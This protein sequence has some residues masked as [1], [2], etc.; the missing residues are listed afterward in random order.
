MCMRRDSILAHFHC[1][2][3]HGHDCDELKPESHEK[4]A[5]VDIRQ[6]VACFKQE[7]QV[8]EMCKEQWEMGILGSCGGPTRMGMEFNPRP[9]K[10]V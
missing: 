5:F 9:R 4:W 8:Y 2:V 6:G 7:L 3:E 1:Q 10:C